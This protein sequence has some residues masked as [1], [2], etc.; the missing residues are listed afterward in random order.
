MKRHT[1]VIADPEMQVRTGHHLGDIAEVRACPALGP[2]GADN[3]FA[4][5]FQNVGISGIEGCIDQTGIVCGNQIAIAGASGLFGGT[6]GDGT[7]S[8][9]HRQSGL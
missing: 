9:F 2:V 1:A 7:E 5:A 3:R 6:G 8:F 4:H